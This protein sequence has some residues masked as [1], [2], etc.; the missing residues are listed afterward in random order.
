M[1]E[2]NYNDNEINSGDDYASADQ[3]V[4]RDP[5][6]VPPVDNDEYRESLKSLP[7]AEIIEGLTRAGMNPEAAEDYANEIDEDR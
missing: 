2:K 7:R 1:E 3:A 5:N 6:Y 4:S